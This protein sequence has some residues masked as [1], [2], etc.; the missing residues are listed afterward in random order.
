MDADRKA[1]TPGD[2][3]NEGLLQRWSRRKLAARTRPRAEEDAPG[4]GEEQ[5]LD[6]L[7]TDVEMPPLELLDADSD[8]SGFLSS[9]VSEELRRDAFRRVFSQPRFNL[10]DGL[11]DYAGDYLSLIHI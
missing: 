9:G 4:K 2:L 6:D 10:T 8:L 7:M 11:D 1:Q 3:E 5:G